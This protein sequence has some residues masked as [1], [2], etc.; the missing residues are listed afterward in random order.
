MNSVKSQMGL[1]PWIGGST[2]LLKS[3]SL[4]NNKI[5][6]INKINN[7]LKMKNQQQNKQNQ[8]YSWFTKSTK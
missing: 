6:K 2:T 5:N 4:L 3:T 1:I 8:G 7:N